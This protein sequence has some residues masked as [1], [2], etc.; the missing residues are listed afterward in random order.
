MAPQGKRKRGDRSYSY[1]EDHSGRPS[2]HR[3]QNLA[4]ASGQQNNSPRGGRRGSRNNGRGGYSNSSAH[5]PNAAQP[6]LMTMSPS[7]N[8]PQA[9]SKPAPLS[10]QQQQQQQQH[11]QLQPQTPKQP[12]FAPSPEKPV[13]ESNEH[14]TPERVANWNTDARNAV[15]EAAVSAQRAGDG[16]NLNIVF[17]EI[18]HAAGE[19]LMSPKELGSIV[20]DICAGPSDELTDP[21]T[22]FL[23][24]ISSY[25]E[26]DAERKADLPYA[27]PIKLL[28]MATEID[29]N[30][31]RRQ[32]ED[33]ILQG[34]QLVRGSFH[35]MGIRATTNAIYRQSNYNLLREETE[36]YAKLM[37]E[38]FTTVNSQSTGPDVASATFER[39][40]ALIGTFDLDVGRVLDVTLDVFANLLVKHHKFFIKYLRV[41]TWWPTQLGN[42]LVEW[43]EPDVKTLPNWALPSSK[44]FSYSDAEKE[45]QLRLREVRDV[46]FWQ[47]A[48]EL[49]EKDA[50]KAFFELG[51]RP[52]TRD[53][54][55]TDDSGS[56]STKIKSASQTWV[57][58]WIADTNTLPPLG[59]EVAAQLLGFKLQFYASDFRDPSDVLPD[60]LIYL[61]ALLIKIGFISLM[62]LW[63]HLYPQGDDLVKL[64]AKLT[65]EKKEKEAKR[66]GKTANALTMAGALSD[67]TPSVP[68]VSRLRDAE[69][70]PSSKQESERNTP[71]KSDE[72]DKPVLPEPVDQKITLL[73]S[74]LCIGAI[75]EALFIIGR[76][77]WMLELCPD[78]HSYIVRLAHHS[79]SKVYESSRPVPPGQV[80]S[81]I[82]GTS[83]PSTT[84]ASDYA[85]RRTL[86]WAKPELKDAGD[87]ID[88]RFYWD[89]WTDNVPICQNVDDVFL[90][91]H[92][93]LGLIGPEC[94]RDVLL[95]TKLARIGRKSILDDS[96]EQNRNRWSDLL[97]TFLMPALT[98][99]GEN[100]GVVNEMWEL[101]K[102][103]DTATRYTIYF[104]WEQSLK[105]AMRTA[106]E[107]VIHK[108][109]QLLNRMSNTN[110]K[111]M[112]RAIAKL[113]CACPVKVFKQTLERGQQYMNMIEALVACSNYLTE[114]GYDCLTFS[115][116]VN[117]TSGNRPTTQSDGMLTEGWLKN[118]AVF[119]A[120]VY[121]KYSGRMDP[122]PIL[123]Y[124]SAQLLNREG[125]L[126]VMK[127]LEELITSMGGVSLSGALSEESVVALCAGPR[128]RRFTLE[129]LGDNRYK[130]LIQKPAERLM[131]HFR[132]SELAPPI[133]VALADQVQAYLYRENQRKVPDKVVLFNYDNLKLNFI[134]FLE[135][136]RHYLSIEEF[137]AQIP[138]LVELISEYYLDTEFAFHIARDSI[139]AK[140]NAIRLQQKSAK[141]TVSTGG[142]VN[143][144]EAPNAECDSSKETAPVTTDDAGDVQMGNVANSSATAE[145]KD[146]KNTTGQARDAAAPRSNSEIDALVSQLQAALPEKFGSHPCLPFHV[147]FWQLSLHDVQDPRSDAL[148]KQYQDAHDRIKNATPPADGRRKPGDIHA[149]RKAREDAE[150][151]LVE[152]EDF[153][154][155]TDLIQSSLRDEMLFWFPG[156]ASMD[157]SLHMTLLQDC[158]LARARMSLQDAQYSAAMLFFMHKSKVPKFRL[159]KILDD[160]F[161]TGRLSAMLF[162]MSEDESK[163]VGRFMNDILHELGRWHSNEQVYKQFEC[164]KILN[165]EGRPKTPDSF[166]KYS[167]F[168]SL[169]GKWHNKVHDALHACVRHGESGDKTLKTTAQYTELRNSI[170]VLKAVAPSF[171]RTRENAASLKEDFK[172][173]EKEA[174]EQRSDIRVAA[175]SLQYEFK[176]NEKR[177]QSHTMFVTGKEDPKESTPA[178]SGTPASS[179]TP[180]AQDPGSK[181]L[182]AAA[183]TF[184][185]KAPTT[186]GT[187]KL[188]S[189]KSRT[190]ERRPG[191]ALSNTPTPVTRPNG[192]DTSRPLLRAP[193]QS[194][195]QPFS[196]RDA[197]KR[198]GPGAPT[199]ANSMP[200]PPR[201]DS[202]GGYQAQQSNWVAHN[203]PTK[204]ETQPLRSRPNER[205][206]E[207]PVGYGHGPGR[208]DV[209]TN[210]PS[211]YG[212]LERPGTQRARSASPSHQSR[213]RS[214]DRGAAPGDRPEWSGREN[215]EY[216]ER[217]FRVPSRDVRAPLDRNAQY[218]DSH[219]DHR[220]NR[221]QRDYRTREP[222][223]ERPDSRAPQPLPQTPAD[224]RGR[225]HAGSGSAPN[226]ALS[227][228]R[229]AAGHHNDRAAYP[230]R[231]LANASPAPSINPQRAALIEQE[232]NQDRGPPVR[233]PY[234]KEDRVNPER[235]V[236]IPEDRSR[237]TPVRSDRERD[238]RN[239]LDKETNQLGRDVRASFSE[240]GDRHGR[241]S[242]NP[243]V[244]EDQIKTPGGR[245]D[246]DVR[247]DEREM[248]RGAPTDRHDDRPPQ[249]Y[250]SNDN[251][252]DYR[253]ERSQPQPYSNPRDRH[254]EF[255]GNAPT[256]PRGGREG[257]SSS[258]VSREMFHPSQSS[259]P[260][261]SR[262]DPNYGRLNQPAET[263]PSGPRNPSSNSRDMRSHPSTPAQSSTPM[264]P[265]ASGVHPSRMSNF[266]GP[267][268]PP[269]PQPPPLQT[270]LANAPSGPRSSGR[271]PLASPSTLRGP[272]TGPASTDRNNRQGR[273]TLGAINSMLV[274]NSQTQSNPPSAP[275]PER[276]SERSHRREDRRTREDDRKADDRSREKRDGSRRDRESRGGERESG[277]ES[278]HRERGD[279]SDRDRRGDD[280]RKD[281]RD[282][283]RKGEKRSR[284]SIDQPHGDSKRSRR[285]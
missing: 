157:P 145:A 112:G 265:Q 96:S 100:P 141:G 194:V 123:E 211:E 104:K 163:N 270:D 235:A 79:L 227:N 36:G 108:T 70:K 254:D 215:R 120:K 66:K 49:G 22:N 23:D 205:P 273:N 34:T 208:H 222:V 67:D 62:D 243:F 275:P 138:G 285:S 274:Q 116:V 115:L 65:T 260:M 178:R 43:Q 279:R 167:E 197:V 281:D 91:C 175:S 284:D 32:L 131:N 147:T 170:N 207:R 198:L 83:G 252:R 90:L 168:R 130:S 216:D 139:T 4:L 233:S 134:Q 8:T 81:S 245:S 261:P 35:Q 262:Q 165:D 234:T 97:A 154:K 68:A 212:R 110:T 272:P 223:R 63:E 11:Q 186:N 185:P 143:M 182:S 237:N 80:P 50:I 10:S 202:R 58:K 206:G 75:P 129:K 111:Q 132:D 231:P 13:P 78:L 229:D 59:N 40:N 268:G 118:A 20:R 228:R 57:E 180:D 19:K 187:S 162:S 263:I 240:V 107:E 151:Y 114:M 37:T 72:E 27:E 119:V 203:L 221:D 188:P 105:P 103:F 122:R 177:L 55:D 239:N 28:L 278:S 258:H 64:Q 156:V 24:C 230:S 41:S 16:F 173:Y 48:A 71:A 33:Y 204:P 236:L 184:Q 52:I 190:D 220:D 248:R 246:R 7:V 164:V 99:T 54:R 155:E 224:G 29:P 210:G 219:R 214:Q 6:S 267:R 117:I 93:L 269:E 3:P 226:D 142:D 277:R 126:F 92:S 259:R 1:D 176:R 218:G 60:N 140:A 148:K 14:L 238:T 137:D 241:D 76:N 25:K 193:E 276:S 244:K 251:R 47:R 26:L 209:R 86:R 160:L 255:S 51:M 113:A 280:R 179:K 213:P 171:P 74:L 31:M 87:G 174:N 152:H 95:L 225:L 232:V 264:A 181:K 249:S 94:G 102:R 46:K 45:E 266:D 73:R 2:P 21:V 169:L 161:N 109:N 183:Q 69:S 121:T 106:F 124:I 250:Y 166:L 56:A 128:L 18:I 217:S 253:N 9:S 85:P 44:T 17:F 61:A 189:E 282:R 88:Y 146:K 149:I 30:R 256:G 195:S 39:V 159:I 135:F 77:R 101:L 242:R 191:A 172:Y 144:E 196:A 53:L 38:Y 136:L 89:D 158:F 125:E 200:V 247:P 201:P 150:K 283:D 199:S 84:R 5:N 15:V 153:V 12:N 257:P 82:K 192:H 271:T 127:V 98:F 133:L 42:N